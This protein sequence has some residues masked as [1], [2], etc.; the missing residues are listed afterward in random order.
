MVNLLRR[1]SVRYSNSTNKRVYRLDLYFFFRKKE[2]YVNYKYVFRS[3]SMII[4]LGEYHLFGISDNAVV[5]FIKRLDYSPICLCTFVAGW[6]WGKY[7][8][9]KLHFCYI[10]TKAVEKKS[11]SF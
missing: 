10:P 5:K 4:V 3:E 1:D 2:F 8:C 11:T 9:S 7:T 6:Y